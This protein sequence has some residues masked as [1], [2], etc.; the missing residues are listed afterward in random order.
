VLGGNSSSNPHDFEFL[1]SPIV[2][3]STATNGLELRFYRW[4][5]VA[6]SPYM[7]TEID[8]YDGTQWVKVWEVQAS[9]PGVTDAS[10]TPVKLDLSSYVNDKLR[11]RFGFKLPGPV[12]FTV[13]NWNIDDVEL[14]KKSCN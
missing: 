5:N 2:D 14:V 13:S 1:T 9:G 8:V 3:A 12:P 10:W 11:I 4:L 7:N 6:A